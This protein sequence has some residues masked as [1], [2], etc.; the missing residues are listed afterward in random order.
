MYTVII[1]G[2]CGLPL[3]TWTCCHQLLLLLLLLLQVVSIIPHL[4]LL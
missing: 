1:K 4:V 3:W 2:E